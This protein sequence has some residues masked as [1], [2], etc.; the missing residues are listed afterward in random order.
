ME[1]LIELDNDKWHRYLELTKN[2]NTAEQ[3]DR[4]FKLHGHELTTQDEIESFLISKK[5]K[6]NPDA[7]INSLYIGFI[8]SVIDCFKLDLVIPKDNRKNRN[9]QS[10]PKFLTKEEV[11]LI[12][13]KTRPRISLLVQLYFET[14]LR[15]RELFNAQRKN[16]NLKNRTISGIGKG[17]KPFNEKYSQKTADRLTK[18]FEQN[19]GRIESIKKRIRETREK[20]RRTATEEQDAFF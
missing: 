3:Y 9:V 14:G 18:M 6:K 20:I 2:T 7:P 19:D 13:N 1:E 5:N 16:F 17:N 11:D 12:I 10:I 15:L 8:K 4:M